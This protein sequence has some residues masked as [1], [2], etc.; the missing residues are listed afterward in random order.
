MNEHDEQTVTATPAIE[1]FS[2]SIGHFDDPALPDLPVDSQ[3]GRVVELLAPFGGRHIPWAAPALERNA[4]AVQHRL[5]QWVGSGARSIDGSV[6]YWVGHGWSDGHRA[7]LAHTESPFRVGESGLS[8]EQLADAI[9]RRQARPGCES[10]VLIVVDTCDSKKFVELLNAQ[11]DQGGGVRNVLLVGVSGEG[12]TTLGRFTD[13]LSRVLGT[14]YAANQRISLRSLADQ[15]EDSLDCKIARHQLGGAQ[16]VHVQPPAAS[17][18]SA[19]YDTILYLEDVLDLLA[20]DERRHFWAKAHGAEYGELSW[21]FEGRTTELFE[22]ATW[23]RTTTSGMLVVCGR[24]G[25]GK[26]ALLGNVMIQSMPD[27]RVALVRRGLATPLAPKD[28]P[29]DQVFHAVIHLSGLTV[30]QIIARIADAAGLEAPPSQHDASV[31]MATDLDWLADSLTRVTGPAAL[32][33]NT[34]FTVLADALDESTDPLDTARSLLARIASILGVRVVVGTRVSTREVVDLPPPD[35]DLLEALAFPPPKA[36]AADGT[37][38]AGSTLVRVTRDPDA[39]RA[40]VRR[41]LLAAKAFGQHGESVHHMREVT[42]ADIERVSCFVA[43]QNREF[44][45]ARLA[46]YELVENARMLTRHRAASLTRLLA[47]DHQDLFERALT[48]L[49]EENDR[50]PALLRALA[51]A[52]GRGVPEADGIW[53][54]M[55]SVLE[56]GYDW[57]EDG[58]DARAAWGSAIEKLLV[59]AAAYIIVDSPTADAP[60]ARSAE[61]AGRSETGTVY[62]LAHRTFAEYFTTRDSRRERSRQDRLRVATALLDTATDEALAT[63]SPGLPTYLAR[64]LSGHIADAGLWDALAGRPAVLDGLDPDAVTADSLRTLFGRRSMPP[65]IAGIISARDALVVAPPADRA[66]LRQMATA[67]HSARQVIDEPTR[68]WGVYAAHARSITPH[69]RLSGHTASL[70]SVRSLNLPGRG[71]VIASASDDHTI[72]L[73]DPATAT[74]IGS[75]LTGHTDTVE[76][77]VPFRRPDGRV[78]LASSGGDGTV[79][80]WDVHTG[81]Q[82]GE[83][84]TG[85]VGRIFGIC[86][87][88][89]DLPGRSVRLATACTDGTVRVWD[90]FAAKQIGRPLAGHHGWVWAVCLVPGTTTGQTLLASCGDDRTVRIWDLRTGEQLGEPLTGHTN[91]VFC[92]C[93]LPDP[94]NE[95]RFLLASAGSDGSVR[96]WNPLTRKEIGEPITGYPGILLTVC[97]MPPQSN[98]RRTLL[99]TTG[100]D[101]TVVVWD[102]ATRE[103]VGYPLASDAGPAWGICV[104]PSQEPDGPAL[105]ATTGSDGTVRVW[106]PTAGQPSGRLLNYRASGARKAEPPPAS[107]SQQLAPSAATRQPSGRPMIQQ[108]SSVRKV[109]VLPTSDL[110]QPSLLVTAGFDGTMR[111][112]DPVVCRA[113]DHPLENVR[114]TQTLFTVPGRTPAEGTLLAGADRDRRLYLWDPDTGERVGGPLGR[115]HGMARTGCVLMNHQ[116]S[117]RRP[118]LVIAIGGLDETVDLWDPVSGRCSG[119]IRT[120][121]TEGVIEVCALPGYTADGRPAGRTFVATFGNDLTVR[122]W[123]PATGAPAGAPL[124]GHTSDIQDICSY[125][126]GGG[127]AER[128]LLA[129]VAFDGTL[130]VWDPVAGQQRGEPLVGHTASILGVCPLPANDPTAPTLLVTTGYDRTVR[131]WSPVTGREV[132]ASLTGHT[133]CVSTACPLPDLRPDGVPGR[134]PLIASAGDDRTVRIWDPN[135]GRAVGEPLTESPDTIR[136]VIASEGTAA[137]CLILAGDGSLHA[138]DGATADLTAVPAPAPRRTTAATVHTTDDTP[139]LLAGDA[140]GLV[141]WIDPGS[142]RR[143]WPPVRVDDGAVLALCPLDG[144][145]LV[146]AAGRSGALVLLSLPHA[147]DAPPGIGLRRLRGHSGPVRDLCVTNTR[148]EQLLISAGDDGTLRVWS[149]PAGTEYRSPLVGHDGPVWSLT[150]LPRRRV[151]DGAR[152]ASASADG[153]VRLWDVCTGRPVTAPLT[154][155]TDQVR[156]LTCTTATDGRTL[157]VSGSFDGTVRLWDCMTGAAVHT[158]PVGVPVHALRQQRPDTRATERTA[159]GATV[160]VGL[161]TGVLVLDLS[162]SIFPQ[163]P[164]PRPLPPTQR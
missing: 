65:A 77:L 58:T 138:W 52:R 136:A 82:A 21:F 153:T 35:T 106:D 27:L 79:R 62:R 76:D 2:M 137:G 98:E 63:D 19:S 151:S 17:W 80:L 104:L 20:P 141:H 145:P 36:V 11:L 78:M 22:I 25:S 90:P 84:L 32:A 74:P 156:A 111:V 89:G 18:M 57:L 88:P 45:Y 122:V 117:Q 7:A 59:R 44:L 113:V 12:A 118:G 91:R 38:G 97:A 93:A 10:W 109:A 144:S 43:G 126:P 39:I 92:V 47:G 115:S 103:Q 75:P 94:V 154:G 146:A 148:N 110:Q 3:V 29:P 161:R 129:T 61:P 67:M 31:G 105:L 123:D 130:R 56:T 121:H 120:D 135:T 72:R 83:P 37:T 24:A 158:I 131:I 40:Y 124:V 125:S 149:V 70:N 4:S 112:W 164:T 100:Y 26:S 5:D 9:R 99:A 159:H 155:H 143:R 54:T 33:A 132:H 30:P 157:L 128:V 55:A 8:P 160:T 87:F 101:G 73:W 46:V 68:S 116:A 49:T 139:M 107:D 86:A 133:G 147:A 119:R 34:P 114:I 13:T 41:R 96:F 162:A 53:A 60:S 95:G 71:T 15:L 1:V 85:H 42:E 150:A 69:V 48:R 127:P 51:L 134:Y 81:Q 28:T 140:T 14:T 16:L 50:F 66:G 6:L 102:P 163:R 23:L 64:H 142:D 108:T 152:V